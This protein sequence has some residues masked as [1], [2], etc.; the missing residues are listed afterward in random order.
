MANKLK[1]NFVN[2]KLV[3]N[4]FDD[5][6]SLFDDLLNRDLDSI[7]S[8]WQWL[9]DRSEL[10]SILEE[11]LAWRYIKMNCNT[12]DSKLAEYFNNFITNIEPQISIYS[13][14]LD[15]KFYS[16]KV[17]ALVDKDRLFTILRE[18]EKDI[19][20]FCEKNIPLE[21][22]VQQKEQEYGIISSKMLI[23]YDEK[24]ITLQQAAN[25]L[26]ENNREVRENIY[27]LINNRRLQD[28]D[29]LNQLLTDLIDLRHKIAVNA[30]FKNFTEYKFKSMGRFDYGIDDCKKFHTSISNVVK[31][32][33]DDILKNRK[34]KLELN[35]LR[36][37]DLDVDEDNR[38]P[39]KPFSTQD[40]LIEKSITIFSELDEN[41]G[42]YLQ[43]MKDNGYLD[44]DSRKNKAPGGFNY[45]LHESNIPFI[46][47]NATGNLRDVVTMMHEGGH[48]VHAFLCSDLELVSFKETPAEI[49]ELASMSMELMTMDYWHHFFTDENELKRAKR[50]HL[51]DVLTILPWIASVDKFQ[52]FLYNNPKHT[53]EE[54]NK[55]WLKIATEFGSSIIDYSDLID[56]KQNQWQKQLHIFEVPFYYIEYG[57]AQLGAIAIWKNYKENKEQALSN[58]K[59]ALKLGYSLPIPKV[60]EQAGIKFNFDK[61]YITELM[62]F[63]QSEINKLQ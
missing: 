31:P 12:A 11:D 3:I 60:Y 27:K 7:D 35:K 28:K 4:T 50:V 17:L 9:L 24:E 21:A 55:E 26:K 5:I 52:H 18:L 13:N 30:G 54:R 15:K 2:K 6:K 56:Y 36:P 43:E 8:V 40:E 25:Y 62:N 49:A 46:Y 51:Q 58:Y 59:Q 19:E 44:L 34:N 10:E 32:I 48:A 61:E 45:P 47:M 57:I 38:Q 63:V 22:E 29:I 33:L 53:V 42:E 41:F 16:D 37:W 14:K 23:K 39:L 20:I 1:R